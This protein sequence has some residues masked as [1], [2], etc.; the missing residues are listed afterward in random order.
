MSNNLVMLLL[1]DPNW[2]RKKAEKYVKK[3]E[4]YEAEAETTELKVDKEEAAKMAILYRGAV[5][6][7]TELSNI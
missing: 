5:M 7:L 2:L 6:C 4:E 1:S 3:I